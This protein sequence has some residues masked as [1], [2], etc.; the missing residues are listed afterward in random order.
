M[1]FISTKPISQVR[2]AF[3]KSQLVIW[4][5]EALSNL[6][7]ASVFE[8]RFGVVQKQLPKILAAMLNLQQTVERHK[9]VLLVMHQDQQA[10]NLIT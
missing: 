10:S 7:S 1:L 8:D 3:A 6:I 5:V 9:V 2:S 4:A